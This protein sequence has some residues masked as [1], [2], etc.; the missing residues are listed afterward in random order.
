MS[1]VPLA[2]TCVCGVDHYH[3]RPTRAAGDFA[4][5]SSSLNAPSPFLWCRQCGSI[6][7]LFEDHWQIPLDRIG[8]LPRSVPLGE[9]EDLPTSPGTPSAKK[10]GT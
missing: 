10:K 5:P 4:S 9:W 8:D 6:R 7:F 3:Q 1:D 2:D